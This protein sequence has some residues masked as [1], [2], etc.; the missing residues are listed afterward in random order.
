M[1]KKLLCLCRA[2]LLVVGPAA[3]A[4]PLSPAGA[5]TQAELCQILATKL[6]VTPELEPTDEPIT[7]AEGIAAIYNTLNS[8]W[9]LTI[10][11]K[12]TVAP[13]GLEDKF[14]DAYQTGMLDLAAFSPEAPMTQSDV[15]AILTAS[16]VDF[17]TVPDAT[18]PAI[19]Y[20][21]YRNGIQIST[22]NG[23]DKSVRVCKMDGAYYYA[24]PDIAALIGARFAGSWDTVSDHLYLTSGNPMSAIGIIWN[25]Q[26]CKFSRNAIENGGAPVNLTYDYPTYIK[27]DGT[28][29]LIAD[30]I[31]ALAPKQIHFDPDNQRIMVLA[32]QSNYLNLIQNSNQL[33]QEQKDKLLTSLWLLYIYDRTDYDLVI[34]EISV[35]EAGDAEQLKRMCGYAATAVA[36]FCNHGNI[37]W[38]RAL[39]TRDSDPIAVA[40]VLVHEATHFVQFRVGDYKEDVPT[41]AGNKAMLT[42]RGLG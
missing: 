16:R 12:K 17:S 36:P 42:L 24:L 8:R 34:D 5:I 4:A 20:I 21:S 22:N 32:T 18:M 3:E 6:G 13:V 27:K 14:M 29:F 1:K 38:D 7:Q 28:V 37:V 15:D 39:L 41:Q 23:S 31:K 19:I 11:R 35:I 33:T 2:A 9:A 30:A 26:T 25:G 40:S 10:Q